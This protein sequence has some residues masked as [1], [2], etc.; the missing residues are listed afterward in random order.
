MNC[1]LAYGY[2]VLNST[3]RKHMCVKEFVD[4]INSSNTSIEAKLGT[5]LQSV[6]GTKQFWFL[7]KSDVIAPTLFLTF[8][9]TA[10]QILMLIFIR[11]M[12]LLKIIL[13][14]NSAQ[15][16]PFLC[17]GNFPKNSEISFDGPFK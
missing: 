2:N 3:A 4:G 6:R 11:L 1:L 15:R 5:V 8:L 12:K 14:A 17:H 7:K 13:Q 10:L 16:V 9:S